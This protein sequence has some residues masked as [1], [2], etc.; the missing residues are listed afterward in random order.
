MSWKKGLLAAVLEWGK[1]KVQQ[2]GGDP[3]DGATLRAKVLD[4]LAS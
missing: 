4:A 3:Q 2:D 1:H